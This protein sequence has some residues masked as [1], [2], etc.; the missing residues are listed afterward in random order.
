MK[1]SIVHEK[2][3]N[4]ADVQPGVLLPLATGARLEGAP[5]AR[6]RMVARAPMKV[7]I[8]RYMLA[9]DGMFKAEKDFL[10]VVEAGT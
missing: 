4:E 1:A 6:G 10:W 3:A 2:F 8:F 5:A 7:C 9:L